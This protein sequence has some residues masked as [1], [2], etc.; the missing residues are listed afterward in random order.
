M[1]AINPEKD[2][3]CGHARYSVHVCTVFQ[4]LQYSI[5]SMLTARTQF[6]TQH[7]AAEVSNNRSISV[8]TSFLSKGS[9]P[10][11]G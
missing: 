7:A 11:I 6:R 2:V 10:H 3:F 1:P 4:K 9:V 5:L 8:Q